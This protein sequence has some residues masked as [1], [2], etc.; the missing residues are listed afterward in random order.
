MRIEEIRINDIYKCKVDD[1][2]VARIVTE[3]NSKGEL[4]LSKVKGE[5]WETVEATIQDI[6]PI[7]VSETTLKTIGAIKSPFE[8]KYIIHLNGVE[9]YIKRD[10]A[11]NKWICAKLHS[12]RPQFVKFSYIHELQRFLL[13][14]YMLTLNL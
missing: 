6:I 8:D 4:V 10:N 14:K 9:F 5:S 1:D 7:S 12:Y 13:D 3:M 2:N 11:S